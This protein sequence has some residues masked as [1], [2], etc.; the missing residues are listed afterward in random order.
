MVTPQKHKEQPTGC[1]S[2][3]SFVYGSVFVPV[4]TLGHCHLDVSGFCIIPTRSL[5]VDKAGEATLIAENG[6]ACPLC[7][8]EA[9]VND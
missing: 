7:A 4:T 5:Y 8:Q 2:A 9:I 3:F 1:S 6:T